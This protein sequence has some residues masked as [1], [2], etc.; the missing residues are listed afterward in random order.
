MQR[1]TWRAQAPAL[2]ELSLLVSKCRRTSVYADLYN[3]R[4][5]LDN[6][7]VGSG[8]SGDMS[9]SGKGLR[10]TTVNA[11][12]GLSRTSLPDNVPPLIPNLASEQLAD[13]LQWPADTASALVQDVSIDHRRPNVTV[14]KE[15]LH[16]PNV[17]ARFNQVRGERVAERVGRRAL[18][19]AGFT[20]RR[21]DRL[22][23]VGFVIVVTISNSGWFIH[24][25][26]RSRKHPLPDPIP[27]RM[28]ELTGQGGRQCGCA[29]PVQE[30]GLPACRCESM[31]PGRGVIQQ[32]AVGGAGSRSTSHTS[33]HH[34]CCG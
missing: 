22:L 30:P 11:T 13:P 2:R 7:P 24:V 1:V 12:G 33:C 34:V 14:P 28:G 21:L 8:R 23:H 18:V 17:I 5:F 10:R 25:V 26:G 4:A 31:P 3:P 15:F 9:R 6:A 27:V 16:G 32:P 20:S 19:Q 29:A